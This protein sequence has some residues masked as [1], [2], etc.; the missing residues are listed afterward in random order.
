[1]TDLITA[2]N[3]TVNR[4]GRKI[5]DDVS[6][7][8]GTYDFITVLKS[9]GICPRLGVRYKANHLKVGYVQNSH[10]AYNAYF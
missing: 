4:G 9:H 3:I 7:K 5:L 10:H 1:M 6:L 2:S 8:V